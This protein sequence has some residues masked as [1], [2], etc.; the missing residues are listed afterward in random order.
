MG[1]KSFSDLTWVSRFLDETP[2]DSVIGGMP[3]QVPHSC[4]SRVKPTS[5]PDPI[6]QL[7]SEEMA[8]E[9]NI[10]QTDN[11]VLGGNRLVEGM[12]PYAQ[13]YGGHQFG[14]WANQLGDGLSLIHI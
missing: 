14:N 7:W 4:W 5:V 10:L 3:R 9:L 12:D 6:I 11:D 8:S 13:R 1:I 2:G